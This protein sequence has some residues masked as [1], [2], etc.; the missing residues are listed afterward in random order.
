MIR[1]PPR[2]TL[3][4]YTTLFRSADRTVVLLRG[5]DRTPTAS[6]PHEGMWRGL[7]RHD[8]D[9]TTQGT[10]LQELLGLALPPVAIA[11][12]AA[13]PAGM[14]RIDA[15]APAGCGDWRPAAAGK[16]FYHEAADHHTC[17]G[18]A[19][20]HGGDPPPAVAQE[21]NGLGQTMVQMQ[22]L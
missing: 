17:P 2:S 12:P 7:R 5:A 22:S 4:P 16:G 15:P 6:A 3:F 14:A 18:G 11:F 20:T 19:P 8:M 9:R 1:R 21:L 10:Q 13:A